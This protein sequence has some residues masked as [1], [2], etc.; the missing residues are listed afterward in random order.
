[1]NQ[2]QGFLL[3]VHQI[4]AKFSRLSDEEQI[5]YSVWAKKK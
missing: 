3:Q 2:L 1:M 5:F 4:L